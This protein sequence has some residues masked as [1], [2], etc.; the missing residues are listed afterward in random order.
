MEGL[1]AEVGKVGLEV[2]AYPEGGGVVGRVL[3]A[4]R[5]KVKD[6]GD[7]HIAECIW[8]HVRVAMN[9]SYLSTSKPES[10]APSCSA[11]TLPDTLSTPITVRSSPKYALPLTY[12]FTLRP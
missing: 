1:Q 4:T 9:K 7:L 5:F 3:A 6:V 8:T 12:A 2:A 10:L 11:C